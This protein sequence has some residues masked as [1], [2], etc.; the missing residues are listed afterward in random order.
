MNLSTLAKATGMDLELA[1]KWLDPLETVFNRYQVNTPRR[2]AH[3]LAQYG[4]E[5]GGFRHLEENGRY[6]AERILVVFPHQVPDLATA[7]TL[8]LNPLKLFNRV[9]GGRMGNQTEGSGDGYRFRGRGLCH[10]TGRANYH[11]A[12][13][14]LGVNFLIDP[15]KLLQPHWA[16]LVGGWFWDRHGLNA[17]A[18]LT[19]STEFLGKFADLLIMVGI[20]HHHL[21]LQ[22]DGTNA[23]EGTFPITHVDPREIL[24]GDQ[25]VKDI[26]K[27]V[28]GGYNGLEDRGERFEKA[29]EILEAA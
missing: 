1:A 6:S 18:D 3:F 2:Q 14:T 20:G 21:G 27:A 4:T 9:Y 22:G 23:H 29:L 25:D 7:K 5:T 11:A 16:A 24:E 28:N 26:T 12:G 8:E 15:D 17:V 13:Q 10:L 19:G